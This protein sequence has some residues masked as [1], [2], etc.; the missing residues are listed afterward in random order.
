M[1][2][3]DDVL[4]KYVT[5][6]SRMLSD[7]KGISITP[8]ELTPSYTH[9]RE[10]HGGHVADYLWDISGTSRF[11]GSLPLLPGVRQGLQELKENGHDVDVLTARVDTPSS[12]SYDWLR[13]NFGWNVDRLFHCYLARKMKLPKGGIAKALG[14]ELAIEDNPTHI[15]SYGEYG[16][17]VLCFSQPWNEHVQESDLVRRVSHWDEIPQKVEEMREG[18]AAGI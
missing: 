15:A 6:L 18:G 8:A 12:I 4:G 17:S 11:M 5:Q 16:I 14:A 7:K 10:T 9:W 13:R 2:D 3:A 1:C